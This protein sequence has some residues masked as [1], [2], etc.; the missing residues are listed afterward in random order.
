[1]VSSTAVIHST[2][3]A[4]PGDIRVL[5][6]D[7]DATHAETVAESLQRVGYDCAVATSRHARRPAHRAG[8]V[9]RRHHRSE[10]GGSRRPGSLGPHQ[11]GVARGGSD[12]GHRPRHDPL[13]RGRDAARGVQ[14]SA[15]AAGSGPSAGDRR[16]GVGG[17]AAAAGQRRTESPARRKIRLRGGDRLQPADERGHRPAEADRSDRRQRADPRRNRHRQGTGRPG[18]PPEQP[19][20]KQAV[21][22]PE[23]R[24]A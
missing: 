17:R 9:R 10:N 14:L 6:V 3:Q 13:G 7:N 2:E 24:R 15:K 12:S 22:R 4:P 23:L 16:K 19:A 1:M 20:E 5:I 21:R 11:A 8:I 18:D